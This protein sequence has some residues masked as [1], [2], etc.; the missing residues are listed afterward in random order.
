MYKITLVLGVSLNPDRYSNMA[1]KRL[2]NNGL[3]VVAYGLKEGEV[4]EININ[5]DLKH[6]QDI[7]TVTIYLNPKRQK[8]FYNYIVSLHPKRV[9]FNPGTENTQ[10]YQILEKNNIAFEVACTLTLLATNQY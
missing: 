6:Y 3:E 7:D 4:S 8:D 9:I 5:T 2:V 1:V 10:L